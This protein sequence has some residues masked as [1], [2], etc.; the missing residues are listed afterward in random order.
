[1]T[2]AVILLEAHEAA[3][4]LTHQLGRPRKI[5]LRKFGFHVAPKDAPK[6]RVF[7][8]PCRLAAWLWVAQS[9]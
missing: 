1:M 5:P 4:L 6:L 8:S 9:L 7:A 2:I 3:W